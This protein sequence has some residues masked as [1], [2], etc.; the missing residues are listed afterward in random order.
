MT[1]MSLNY[2]DKFAMSRASGNCWA[3]FVRAMTTL[4]LETAV[5]YLAGAAAVLT[6]VLTLP[7]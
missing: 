4:T 5:L 6:F 7:L 3:R 2:Q 1:T